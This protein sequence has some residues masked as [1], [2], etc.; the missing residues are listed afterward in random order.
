MSGASFKRKRSGMVQAAR[1]AARITPGV[2]SYVRRAIGRAAEVKFTTAKATT[3]VDVTPTLVALGNCAQG[4]TGGT[5]IGDV[6]TIVNME[7]RYYLTVADLNNL[8]RVI[9]FKWKPN[10]GYIAP[11]G[12]DIL[13]DAA[14]YP[15]ISAYEEDGN[16]QYSI[17]YDRLHRMVSG[18]STAQGQGSFMISGKAWKQEYL[19]GSSNCSN[20]LYL[21]VVS[22]SGVAVHPTITWYSRVG[23]TDE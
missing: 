8:L 16:D 2:K 22:D 4:N 15:L 6:T 13:K 17:I 20:N 19:T 11:T 23:F 14:S 9:V 10:M 18:T 3:S 12:G 1:K 5:H 7:L 21:L